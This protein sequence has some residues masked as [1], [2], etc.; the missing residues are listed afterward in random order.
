ME[1]GADSERSLANALQGVPALVGNDQQLAAVVSACV[2][3]VQRSAE[4]AD[5]IECFGRQGDEARRVVVET[6]RGAHQF[7]LDT[8]AADPVGEQ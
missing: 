4:T 2:R 3:I 6:W 7:A 8:E 1:A 5:E